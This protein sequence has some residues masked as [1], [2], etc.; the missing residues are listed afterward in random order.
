MVDQKSLFLFISV[1]QKILPRTVLKTIISAI[2]SNAPIN[3]LPQ[4]W[5]GG[6]GQPRVKGLWKAHMGDDFDNHNG[7]Q[8]GKFYSTAILRSWEDLEMSDEWCAILENSQDSFEQD[9]R[10][11]GWLNDR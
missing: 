8:G 11:Q 4:Y 7:P 6:F 2:R 5:K 10:V 3:G 1:T 9:S